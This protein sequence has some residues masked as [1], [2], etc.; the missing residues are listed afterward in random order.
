MR[1]MKSELWRLLCALAFL[2]SA[3]LLGYAAARAAQ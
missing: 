2:S 1:E 3:C